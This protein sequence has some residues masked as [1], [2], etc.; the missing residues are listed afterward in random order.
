MLLLCVLAAFGAQTQD[1]AEGTAEP[2]RDQNS[3]LRTNTW[4]IFAQGG[5]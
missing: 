5:V 4:S 3:E 2:P 1:K